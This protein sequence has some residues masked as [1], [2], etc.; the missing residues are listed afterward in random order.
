MSG[1]DGTWRRALPWD[2]HLAHQPASTHSR[3]A[4]PRS[5]GHTAAELRESSSSLRALGWLG[6]RGCALTGPLGSPESQS[7]ERL[8][9]LDSMWPCTVTP[10]EGQHGDTHGRGR[11]VCFLFPS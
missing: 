6:A 4:V 10:R 11:P 1:V 7:P 8:W 2:T 9:A 3:S 5:P